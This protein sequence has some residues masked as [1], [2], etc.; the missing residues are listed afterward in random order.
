MAKE[1]KYKVVLTEIE[2]Q[3]ALDSI[4]QTAYLGQVS[5]VVSSLRAKLDIGNQVAIGT[6]KRKPKTETPKE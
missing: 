4:N 2:M 6:R 3:T 1:P 5:D